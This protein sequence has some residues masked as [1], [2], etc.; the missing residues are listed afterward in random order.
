MLIFVEKSN[1]FNVNKYFSYIDLYTLCSRTEGFPNIL[2]EIFFHDYRSF[3]KRFFELI[4]LEKCLIPLAD[5]KY[6]GKKI[7]QNFMQNKNKM[8]KKHKKLKLLS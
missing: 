6:F 3:N 7:Y 1:I 4:V 8:L 2:V 5:A